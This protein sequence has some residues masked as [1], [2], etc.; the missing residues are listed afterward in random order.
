MYKLIRYF[1]E[2]YTN[3]EEVPLDFC[4]HIPLQFLASFRKTFPLL[5]K[6]ELTADDFILYT[7]PT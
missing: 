2:W 6:N 4:H 7:T 5:G 1:N 3:E